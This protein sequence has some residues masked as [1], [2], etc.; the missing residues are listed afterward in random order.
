MIR[1]EVPGSSPGNDDLSFF[2]PSFPASSREPRAWGAWF[3][4]ARS[5]PPHHDEGYWVSSTFVILR[6][7]VRPVSKDAG[8]VIRME[9]PGSSP[10]NDDRLYLTRHSRP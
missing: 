7:A 4:M 9:V 8:R 1:T 3:E 6:R 5:G 2:T 10:G